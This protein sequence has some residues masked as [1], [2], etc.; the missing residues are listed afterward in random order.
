[1]R[2]LV[3]IILFN[4]VAFTSLR[5]QEQITRTLLK[6]DKLYIRRHYQ[7]AVEY[8]VLYLQKY[9]KDYYACRQAALCYDKLNDPYNAIDYWPLVVESSE[10]GD[11]D[12]LAYAKSLLANDREPEAKKIFVFL[13]KSRNPAAAAWGKAYLNPVFA[14][15]DTST[16]RAIEISDI[17]TAASEACPLIFN[18]KLFYVL[19]QN[20]G[21]KHYK[22]MDGESVQN[23]RIAVPKDSLHFI[24]SLLYEKLQLL[25]IHEQFSFSPGG[26]WLYFSRAVSNKEMKISSRVDFFRYQIFRLRMST[27]KDPIP[28]IQPFEH[29]LPAFNNLHPC[30]SPD[31]NWFVFSS[32]RKGSAGAMDIYLCVRNGESWSEPLNAGTEVNSTGNEVYPFISYD[33]VLYFSSDQRPGMGGLDVF[34]S[35]FSDQP[36]TLFKPALNCR[37]P[38]NS[39]FDDFGI[40]VLKGGKKGYLSSK[41]KNNKDEDLY[42]FSLSQP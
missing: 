33:N 23:I 12:Y 3:L 32:D 37:V 19:N 16:S 36:E 15:A 38:V 31:G 4:C 29:N 17:N 10:A 1:M 11:A 9:P 20:S 13:S 34:Y 30:I 39:R 2:T 22:A 21:A 26:E 7:K 35:E 28:D 42:F 18:E 24:P 41:R 6:A 5:A 14:L 8:Y 27:L 40:Y 25:N